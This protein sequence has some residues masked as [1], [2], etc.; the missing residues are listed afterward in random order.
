MSV[1][2]AFYLELDEG[3]LVGEGISKTIGSVVYVG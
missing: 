3:E 2:V 1:V